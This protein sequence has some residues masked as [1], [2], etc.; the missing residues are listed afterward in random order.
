MVN[1]VSL[2]Y[3]ISTATLI[4]LWQVDLIQGNQ[5]RQLTCSGGTLSKKLMQDCKF[6]LLRTSESYALD[7]HDT[8]NL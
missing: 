2:T 5:F 3:T 6:E 1:I 7:P 8:I 4:A